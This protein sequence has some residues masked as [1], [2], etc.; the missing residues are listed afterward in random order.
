MALQS[1][2]DSITFDVMAGR[3]L[4]EFAKR[5]VEQVTHKAQ[6][7]NS[8]PGSETEFTANRIPIPR[9]SDER[10]GHP[11]FGRG[12]GGYHGGY[13]GQYQVN[14]SRQSPRTNTGAARGRPI[15]GTKCY[16][17]EMEGHWKKDCYK[18]KTE[19]GSSASASASKEFTLLA[20]EVL[21]RPQMGWIID[22]EA[23]QHLCG[24]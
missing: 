22:S 8:I 5:Q 24:D 15:S 18:R 7:N 1:R 4:Q 2:T 23:S 9:A 14:G 6:D 16:Y 3:L 13:R 17:C 20:Q 11:V 10:T 21:A 12:Q 19:E